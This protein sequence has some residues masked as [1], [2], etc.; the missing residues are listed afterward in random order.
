M[1][2]FKTTQICEKALLSVQG[3]RQTNL[4]REYEGKSIFKRIRI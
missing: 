4:I 1:S 2:P 3:E